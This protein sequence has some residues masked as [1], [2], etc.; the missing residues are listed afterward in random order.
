[1]C[2]LQ[3]NRDTVGVNY[4]VALLKRGTDSHFMQGTDCHDQT[5]GRKGPSDVAVPL[6]RVVPGPG[7]AKSGTK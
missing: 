1:M 7:Q 6:F 4:F 5:V 2:L 3:T